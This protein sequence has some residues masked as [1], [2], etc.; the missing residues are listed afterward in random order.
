MAVSDACV[1]GATFPQEMVRPEVIVYAAQ[2][3]VNA[4]LAEIGSR[5]VEITGRVELEYHDDIWDEETAGYRC[6][7]RVKIPTGPVE[8]DPIRVDIDDMF[9]GKQ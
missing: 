1:A 3:A 7:V 8:E 4:A 6:G 9:R 5:G 2:S